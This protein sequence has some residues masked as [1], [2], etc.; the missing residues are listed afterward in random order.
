M[1]EEVGIKISV[2]WEYL[3]QHMGEE[4]IVSTNSKIAK[5]ER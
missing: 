1:R 5:T 2:G 4:R 3:N